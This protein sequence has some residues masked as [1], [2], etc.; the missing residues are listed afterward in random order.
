MGGFNNEIELTSNSKVYALGDIL[1]GVPELTPVAQKS[2]NFLA[3]RIS[4][5]KNVFQ[6][7]S[8]Y[9]KNFN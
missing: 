3:R 4:A 1:E 9:V 7:N 5:K 6:N 8:I 2:A